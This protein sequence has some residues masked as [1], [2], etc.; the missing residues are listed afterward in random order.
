LAVARFAPVQW[1]KTA[2]EG[3]VL[4]KDTKEVIKALVTH[5]VKN[6]VS[7]DLIRGKGSGL[8]LLF[9]G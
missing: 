6:T 8:I 1:D 3:L 7:S 4:E 5:K 9:H 2:F